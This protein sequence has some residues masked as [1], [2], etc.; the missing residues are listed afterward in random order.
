M[1]IYGLTLALQANKASYTYSFIL[2]NL[3][4]QSSAV[5]WHYY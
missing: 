3:L 2:L 1:P 4:F 5:Y